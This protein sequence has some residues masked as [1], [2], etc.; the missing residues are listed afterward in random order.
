MDSIIADLFLQRAVPYKAV[1]V[2]AADP[3]AVPADAVT[4][5]VS[6]VPVVAPA[7][8]AEVMVVEVE[9]LQLFF[10]IQ[11]LVMDLIGLQVT[12]TVPV[13]VVTLFGLVEEYTPALVQ[14]E[15]LDLYTQ[16]VQDHIHQQM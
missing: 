10:H 15:R 11:T 3:V 7:V 9:A 2:A 12:F 8:T 5:P 1:T 14:A 6:M 13:V 16:V 4:K